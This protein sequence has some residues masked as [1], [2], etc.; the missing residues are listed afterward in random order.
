MATKKSKEG[1]DLSKYQIGN[2]P[3]ETQ[4]VIEATGDTFPIT[5]RP[6]SWSIRNQLISKCLNWSNDGNTSFSGDVYVR[7]CLKAV[8]YT[9]LTLPTTPYV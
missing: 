3:N 4:V 2:A 8:S 6:M 1:F 5:I 9:H 7:E